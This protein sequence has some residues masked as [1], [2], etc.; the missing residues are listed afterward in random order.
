MRNK[1]V[2]LRGVEVSLITSQ[3]ECNKAFSRRCEVELPCDGIAR[4]RSTGSFDCV[5]VRFAN[6]HFGQDDS[7]E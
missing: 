7:L 3:D 4:S 6:V 5:V 1:S 2:I